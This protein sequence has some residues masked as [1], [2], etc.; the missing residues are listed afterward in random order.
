[1]QLFDTNTPDA[2]GKKFLVHR[3]TLMVTIA[4]ELCMSRK[5]SRGYKFRNIRNSMMY[6]GVVG[7]RLG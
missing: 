6:I 7:F 4:S 5:C 2:D 1:M 3:P